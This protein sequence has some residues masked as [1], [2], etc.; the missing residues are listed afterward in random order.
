MKY[1]A[2]AIIA[3]AGLAYGNGR[4]V[5][6]KGKGSAK[7]GSKNKSG[8][9]FVCGPGTRA[10]VNYGGIEDCIVD[11]SACIGSAEWAGHDYGDGDDVNPSAACRCT[12]RRRRL[13]NYDER[14]LLALVGG[15]ERDEFLQAYREVGI[16]F[17]SLPSK[18]KTQTSQQEEAAPWAYPSTDKSILLANDPGIWIVENFLTDEQSDA[19]LKI[20]KK[21]GYDKGMFGPCT[22]AELQEKGH[23]H[24]ESSSKVCFKMSNETLHNEIHFKKSQL[25]DKASVNKGYLELKGRCGQS[26]CSAKTDP[27]DGE[28]LESIFS[29]IKSLWSTDHNPR[30]HVSVVLATGTAPPLRVHDDTGILVSFVLYLTDGGASTVFPNAGVTINPK[31]GALATWLNVRKDGSLN[32][33][34]AHGVQ[35]HPGFAGERATI[36]IFFRDLTPDEFVISQEDYR[37][38]I[39]NSE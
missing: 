6:E 39:T 27:E 3:L 11:A 38:S 15:K 19:L 23:P 17:E 28:V 30:P 4:K 29:N 9:G 33:M 5:T 34:A 35:A 36:N 20:V 37:R 18:G 13:N 31:K 24:F 22:N 1:A 26:S 21:N 32:T 2:I 25:A 7:K 8:G 10:R 12:G 16:E 14:E